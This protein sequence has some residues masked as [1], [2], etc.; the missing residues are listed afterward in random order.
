MWELFL[1][2]RREILVFT[3]PATISA[4][5]SSSQ[6]RAISFSNHQIF[7]SLSTWLPLIAADPSLFISPSPDLRCLSLLLSFHRGGMENISLSSLFSLLLS[8]NSD[9]GAALLA[10]NK[11]LDPAPLWEKPQL[12]LHKMKHHTTLGNRK[13]FSIITYYM[14]LANQKHLRWVWLKQP[15]N[16]SKIGLTHA[17]SETHTRTRAHTL[18]G[19]TAP[20]SVWV[21]LRAVFLAG[22][23][24]GNEYQMWFCSHKSKPSAVFWL[25]FP[26]LKSIRR[27]SVHYT[28]TPRLNSFLWNSHRGAFRSWMLRRS[29]GV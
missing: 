18:E 25:S 14:C 4:G 22:H 20:L 9:C 10:F 17:G 15:Q 29:R 6:Q 21:Y 16:N 3:C 2:H 5:V 11:L 13:V 12:R 19:Y 27:G 1:F 23:S 8:G 24:C 26:R 7:S 28:Y